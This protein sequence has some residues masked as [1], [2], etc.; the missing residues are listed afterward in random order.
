MSIIGSFENYFLY[1]VKFLEK[2]TP[3]IKLNAGHD[4]NLNNLDYFLKIQYIL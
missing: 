3:T 2:I 1:V 4:L